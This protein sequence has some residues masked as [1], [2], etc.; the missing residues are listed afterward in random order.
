MSSALCQEIGY[1]KNGSFY[2]EWDVTPSLNQFADSD[3][4]MFHQV[5][6][7]LGGGGAV[8][9]ELFSAPGRR[10]WKSQMAARVTGRSYVSAR[11]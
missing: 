6:W 7:D 5:V 4:A 10:S 1:A 9:S 3:V 8:T 11:L 2:V